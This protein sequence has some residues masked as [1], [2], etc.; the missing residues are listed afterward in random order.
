[1]TSSWLALFA[2]GVQLVL[3]FGHV[4]LDRGPAPGHSSVLLRVHGLLAANVVSQP[5]TDEAPRRADDYCAVCAL[6][7]DRAQNIGVEL[8]AVYNN[9]PFRAYANWA[10]ARQKATNIVSNQ[11]LF[12]LDEIAYIANHYIYTDHAQ[13]WTGSAGMSYL[14][15]GIG[16]AAT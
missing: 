13:V 7:Y 6:N 2:L 4:H 10:W 1:M 12:G 9:G 11:Y 15:N 14:W 16:L 3:S 8:K 5:A